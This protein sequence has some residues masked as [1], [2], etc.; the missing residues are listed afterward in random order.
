MIAILNDIIG[1]WRLWIILLDMIFVLFTYFRWEQIDKKTN[2][3]NTIQKFNK[4]N[5]K[6]LLITLIIIVI[7]GFSI[8]I[9]TIPAEYRIIYLP[10][11]FYICI[12][13]I[14]RLNELVDEYTRAHKL[15]LGA[16]AT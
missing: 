15:G 14:Y 9:F 3:N 12:K 6:R 5:L 2:I 1:D 13:A 16:P 7:T 10:I 8:I 4:F 11:S